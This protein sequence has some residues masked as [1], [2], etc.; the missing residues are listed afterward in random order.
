MLEHPAAVSPEVVFISDLH[1]HP[2]DLMIQRRF[3]RFMQWIKQHRPKSLYIL[4]DLFHVWVGDDCVDEWIVEIAAHFQALT[5]QGMHVYFMPGNRDFLLGNVYAKLA[6]F[7]LLED[8][9]VIVLGNNLPVLLAHGDAYC[10]LDIAHQRFRKFSRHPLARRIF[11]A[12]P[13]SL[14]HAIVMKIRKRSQQNH[15]RM[16]TIM[17]VVPEACIRAMRE[18]GVHTLIHG[19][20]HRPGLSLYDSTG[21][22][23][24]SNLGV[25]ERYVLSDWDDT[26]QVL[27]YYKSKGLQFTHFDAQ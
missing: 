18:F 26:P 13:K 24:S 21:A 10:L 7:G 23:C 6:G 14:R 4:G 15:H 27:C 5:E 11:L 3:E 12:T 25:F 9:T 20:T 8:P 16:T 22:I 1:L 2:D 17:D 19:H